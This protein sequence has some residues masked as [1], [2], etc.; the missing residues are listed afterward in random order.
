MGKEPRQ[1]TPACSGS[2]A[3]IRVSSAERRASAVLIGVDVA[4][5]EAVERLVESDP[6]LV[7]HSPSTLLVEPSVLEPAEIAALLDDLEECLQQ[8]AASG[9]NIGTNPPARCLT[10]DVSHGSEG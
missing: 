3:E 7:P 4:D 5:R 8:G 6:A 2:A 1:A 10:A 9:V